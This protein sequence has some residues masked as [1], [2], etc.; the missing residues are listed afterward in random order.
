ME[1][2][3][4]SSFLFQFISEYSGALQRVGVNECR[5]IQRAN[6]IL[7]SLRDLQPYQVYQI[8]YLCLR[9]DTI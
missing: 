4:L 5:S 3:E 9:D 2:R 6:T 8:H 7:L 1:S